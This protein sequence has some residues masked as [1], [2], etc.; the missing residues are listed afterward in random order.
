MRTASVVM[1]VGLLVA[2]AV[3]S[4][5]D[6]FPTWRPDWWDPTASLFGAAVYDFESA[7]DNPPCWTNPSRWYPDPPPGW[8]TDNP[9][10]NFC[11]WSGDFVWIMPGTAIYGGREGGFV[12][13]QDGAPGM[14]ADL[15]IG[16]DNSHVEIYAKKGF[17]A[18]DV[19]TQLQEWEN[20][21]AG[22]W[23]ESS[24]GGITELIWRWEDPQAGGWRQLT[25]LYLITP[26]PDWEF[27]H[28]DFNVPL[29]GSLILDQACIASRCFE[30][31]ATQE[32]SWTEIKSLF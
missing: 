7:P 19:F 20:L 14:T 24:H 32:T 11:C 17:V 30:P 4:S 21:I 25:V 27:V 2:M 16:L 13:I 29:G 26:Q 9:A 22:V 12:G 3:P 10:N 5:A 28:I 6:E 1:A 15:E 23:V 31:T 18:V 8:M